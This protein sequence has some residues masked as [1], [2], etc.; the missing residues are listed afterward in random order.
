MIIEP[1]D[2]SATAVPA[3][4]MISFTGQRTDTGYD[5]DGN[6]LFEQLQ[7]DIG[8]DVHQAGNYGVVALLLDRN[9]RR[10]TMGSL[11]PDIQRNIPA[12][13]ALLD[14]G[15]QQITVY[16]NGRDLRQ[17]QINGPYTVA[18]S[19]YSENGVLLETSRFTTAAYDT[20]DFQELLAGFLGARDAALDTNNRPGFNL[21]RVTVHLNALAAGQIT[22]EGQLFAGDTFLTDSSTTLT[23]AAGDHLVELDFPGEAIA[24]SNLDGPYTV[25][26]TIADAN[27]VNNVEFITAAYRS[28]EFESATAP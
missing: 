16:F 7:V 10:L 25:Y 14:V 9:D 11:T 20:R 28:S 24:A 19:L 8:V 15:Q 17:V 18:I 23:P 27:Y 22:I 6:G 1:I 5:A 3:H 2:A 26:L 12:M 21:L 13:G 4:T